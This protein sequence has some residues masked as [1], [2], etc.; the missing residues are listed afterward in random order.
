M[1][2]NTQ[3]IAQPV[4]T[5]TP[6]ALRQ[7]INEV[8]AEREKKTRTDDVDAV[9]VR[10]F[11]K[12]G[13]EEQDIRPRENTLTYRRWIEL[14][15][16]VKPGEHAV[17][18]RNLRLFHVSQTQEI[19]AKEKAAFLAEREARRTADNLPKPSPVAA[20]PPKTA[21]KAEVVPIN[22]AAQVH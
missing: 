4:P 11:K 6:E 2:R 15:R 7:I 16:K 1:A 20:E 17:K 9:V 21:K 12:K 19:S 8:L 22:E 5:L 14:G 10:A 3:P 13:Y 18:C